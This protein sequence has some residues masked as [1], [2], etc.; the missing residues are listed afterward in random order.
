MLK[1]ILIWVAL[2]GICLSA[3]SIHAADMDDDDEHVNDDI[4]AFE[5]S[6]NVKFSNQRTARFDLQ[7][8]DG[9]WQET[10]PRKIVPPACRSK[11][12]PVTVQHSHAAVLEFSVWG[13]SVAKD[14][15]DVSYKFKVVHENKLVAV[16]KDGVS[17]TMTRITKHR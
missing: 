2:C 3:A 4:P 17:V 5:G 12:I 8:W 15:P 6:W 11:K 10:G 14:C 7:G 16:T 13:S 9:T 1:K